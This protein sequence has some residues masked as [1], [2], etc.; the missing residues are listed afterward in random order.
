MWMWRMTSVGLFG[1]VVACGHAPPPPPPP[2]TPESR[3]PLP[4][5]CTIQNGTGVY[6]AEGGF[7]GMGPTSLMITHFTN[8]PTVTAQARFFD[9]T[10]G[11]WTLSPPLQLLAEYNGKTSQQV[12]SLT[13]TSTV[14]TWGL[15]DPAT[16]STTPVTGDQLPLL[17][18]AITLNVPGSDA[19]V[20]LLDFAGAPHDFVGPPPK[21]GGTWKTQEPTYGMQWT[22]PRTGVT[23]QYCHDALP[24][25]SSAPPPGATA[26]LPAD[27]VVFQQGIDVDPVTGTVTGVMPDGCS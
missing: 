27:S 25:S 4:T 22:D 26:S 1:L 20:Y 11:V 3:C 23:T 13:E 8:G 19:N 6:F 16:G 17:K 7:A 15:R 10:A 24:G 2:P 12:I 14:P 21:N 5:S 9:S 18:L